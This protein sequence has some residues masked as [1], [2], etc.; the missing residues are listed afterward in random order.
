MGP[1]K[2]EH[3]PRV[4]ESECFDCQRADEIRAY[5]AMG[6]TQSG[7]NPWELEIVSSNRYFLLRLGPTKHHGACSKGVGIGMTWRCQDGF[8]PIEDH[9]PLSI[10]VIYVDIVVHWYVVYVW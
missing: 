6:P 9:R 1:T 10:D 2:S 5:A 8:I 3:V 7:H 4:L